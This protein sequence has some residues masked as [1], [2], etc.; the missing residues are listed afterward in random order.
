MSAN[1]N[2]NPDQFAWTDVARERAAKE[3]PDLSTDNGDPQTMWG[4]MQR[5]ATVNRD[6]M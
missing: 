3:V 2:L 6:V 1:D 5:N 4:A